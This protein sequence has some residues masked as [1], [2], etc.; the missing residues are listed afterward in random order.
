MDRNEAAT[1]GLP[2]C[3]IEGIVGTGL[4]SEG[5]RI[6]G[7][8][9]FTV[10]AYVVQLKRETSSWFP[11]ESGCRLDLFSGPGDDLMGGVEGGSLKLFIRADVSLCPS[12][13]SEVRVSGD[14]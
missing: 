9:S 7:G 3:T 2:G 4:L 11:A 14:P 10:V 5:M 12:F 13:V 6:F 1:A 8:L